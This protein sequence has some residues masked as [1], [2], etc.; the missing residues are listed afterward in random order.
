[1]YRSTSSQSQSPQCNLFYSA[2]THSKVNYYK[3]LTPKKIVCYVS[4]SDGII[5]HKIAEFSCSIFNC[6]GMVPSQ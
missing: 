3:Y 1:M 5:L 2:L 6:A 4:K